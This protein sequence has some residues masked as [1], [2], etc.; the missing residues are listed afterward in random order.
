MAQAATLQAVEHDLESCT[1]LCNEQ[2]ATPSG[3]QLDDQVCNRLTLT[4]TWRPL[5]YSVSYRENSSNR[6][7]LAGVGVKHQELVVRWKEV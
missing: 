4:R 3:S 1:F 7:L 6:S 2:Y 5:D